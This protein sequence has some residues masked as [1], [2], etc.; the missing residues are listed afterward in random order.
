MPCYAQNSLSVSKPYGNA[1]CQ[2]FLAAG[3]QETNR[4]NYFTLDTCC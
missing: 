3:N 1:I 2:G 4:I